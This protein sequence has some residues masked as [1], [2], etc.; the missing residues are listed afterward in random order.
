LATAIWALIGYWLLNNYHLLFEK[1]FWG[2]ITQ[3]AGSVVLVS[4]LAI[5]VL[6]TKALSTKR[7]FGSS[8]FSE[9]GGALMTTD[10]Y[11]YARHPR[12]VE[13]PFWFLGLGLLFSYPAL[14]WFS[15]YLFA[16]FSVTAYFEER[17]LIRR[18]GQQYLEYKKQVPA[19]FF[20]IKI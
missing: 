18:Y 2:I 11:K 14:I 4:A 17:E 10:I 9:D 13:H 8:E 3:I 20:R 12:Y 5:E 19:F 6:T 15:I 16:A 7:I 1:R